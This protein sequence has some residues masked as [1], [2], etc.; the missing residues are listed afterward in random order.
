MLLAAEDSTCSAFYSPFPLNPAR[1]L[2]IRHAESEGNVDKGAYGHTP[3]YALRLSQLGEQQAAAAGPRLRALVGDE[4]VFAYVSPM[5]RTRR[6]FEHLAAALAPGLGALAGRAPHPGAGVGPL[7]RPGR[8]RPHGG[9]PRRLRH[10]LLP[11][12]R[13]RVGGRRLRPGERL[14][15]HP[16]P[17]LWQAGLSRKR[18]DRHPR[19]DPAPVPDAVVSLDGGRL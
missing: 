3:Y 18:A 12:P 8:L 14:L 15:R 1:I 11:H 19:H 5:W 2:L 6:T 10:V 7:P 4:S 16:A 9:Q 17:G 13:G